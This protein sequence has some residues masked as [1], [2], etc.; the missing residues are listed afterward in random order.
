LS[1]SPLKVES[2][3]ANVFEVELRML[4]GEPEVRLVTLTSTSTAT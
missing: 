4:D 3:P 2:L 1:R